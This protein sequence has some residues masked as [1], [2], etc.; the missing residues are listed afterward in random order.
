M[1]HKCYSIA[2]KAKS[3]SVMEAQS[4]LFLSVASGCLSYKRRSRVN[5]GLE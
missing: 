2:F 4:Y 3:C 5:S 1:S